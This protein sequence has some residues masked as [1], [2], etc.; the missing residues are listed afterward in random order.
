MYPLCVEYIRADGTLGKGG[1]VFLSED[2]IHDHQQVEAFEKRAFQIFE[3]KLP[4]HVRSWKRYSDGCGGQFW[5]RFVNANKFKMKDELKLD[6]L[7]YDRFEAHEGKSI[8]DTLGSITKRCFNR[9]I[10]KSGQGVTSLSDIVN[11]IRT[12]LKELT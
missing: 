6:H 3:D 5:S 7:S 8:S 9:A 1:I 2:K 12:E 10:F 4:N 11:L